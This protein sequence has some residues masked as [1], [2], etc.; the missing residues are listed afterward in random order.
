MVLLVKQINHRVKGIEMFW[1]DPDTAKAILQLHAAP[2]RAKT[3]AS[4]ATSKPARLALCQ[5]A[6]RIHRRRMS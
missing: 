2:H 6:H 4:S 1:N 5:T 3:A